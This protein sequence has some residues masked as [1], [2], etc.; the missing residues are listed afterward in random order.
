MTRKK[1]CRRGDVDAEMLGGGL[2]TGLVG[3]QAGEVV[4]EPTGGGQMDGVER[5]DVVGQQPS[6]LP[7][8]GVAD[9]DEVDPGQDG[10]ASVETLGPGGKQG[11]GDFG[12]G[13][14]ARDVG[15]ASAEI[16]A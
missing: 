1:L 15:R 13:E 8:D 14:G 6:R 12:P 11:T 9:A 4:A 7:Q 16:A 3:D 2:Q 10:V 5:A